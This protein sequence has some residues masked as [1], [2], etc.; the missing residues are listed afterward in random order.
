MQA[1]NMVDFVTDTHFNARGR[2][3]RLIPVLVDLSSPFGFGVDENTSFYYNNGIGTV[4]GWNGV[5]IV[6]L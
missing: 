6:D 1:F 3:G 5:T 4:Y 2:L